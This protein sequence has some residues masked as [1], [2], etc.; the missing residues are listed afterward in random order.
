MKRRWTFLLLALFLLTLPGLAEM[1]EPQAEP[2]NMIL[3]EIRQTRAEEVTLYFRA[4]ETPELT[5]VT[6]MLIVEDGED[7]LTKALQELLKTTGGDDLVSPAPTETSLTRVKKSGSLVTVDLAM[8]LA[9]VQSEQEL[10]LLNTAV[11]N[12]LT[13]LEDV[14][15]VNVL[16]NSRQES[17]CGLP[18][19]VLTFNDATV[20]LQ[21]A[22]YQTEADRLAASVDAVLERKAALYFPSEDGQWILPEVRNIRFTGTDYAYTLLNEL[23]VGPQTVSAASELFEAGERSPLSRPTQFINTLGESVLQ[24]DLPEEVRLYAM[25]IGLTDWQY[26]AALT[27]TMCSFVPELD[28]AYLIIGEDAVFQ[29]NIRGERME[30][31]DVILRRRDFEPYIGD[32]AALYLSDGQG[33]LKRVVRAVSPVQARSARCRLEQLIEGPAPEDGDAGAVMPEGVSALDVLGVEWQED[34]VTVN[35]S[36][37]FYRLCQTMDRQ[38]ERVAVFAIVNTLCELPSVSAVRI[39]IE[40]KAVETLADSIYLM[41]ELLP[42]PGL[43]S[44]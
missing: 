27:E 34:T 23:L 41:G 36:A 38:A 6:R 22:Q 13:G 31:P 40:G 18:V 20:A 12:T 37:D 17:V 29:M 24:I 1:P 2:E 5:E 4:G 14:E 43:V 3:G 42:N 30:F 16:I 15:Y 21:W 39:L 35:L 19:G 10:V 26:A 8:D 33:G 7:L 9:N 44:Q 11:A 32:T 28:A 25:Q